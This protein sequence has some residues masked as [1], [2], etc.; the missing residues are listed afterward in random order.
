MKIRLFSTL[1]SFLA[2]TTASGFAQG[3][4][5]LNLP[6]GQSLLCNQLDHGSNTADILFP[7]PSG[8]RD[9]DQLRYEYNC[10][11][12]SFTIVTFDSAQ[13]TGFGDA[14]DINPVPAPVL[15]PGTG[16]FYA[17]NSVSN[18]ITFTGTPHVPVLPIRGLLTCGDGTYYVL[19]RQTNDIGTYE[20]ITGFSPQEGS[21]VQTWNGFGFVTNR[22]SSG[23]WTLGAPSLGVGQA[24]KFFIPSGATSLTAR[25]HINNHTMLEAMANGYYQIQQE[26]G[27]D[28]AS[29]INWT[30]T[31]N[32]TGWTG[33][34]IGTLYNKSLTINYSGVTAYGA[35]QNATN[36]F[37]ASG[38]NGTNAIT[39][40]GAAVWVYN[41]VTGGYT[42]M[43][44]ED[45]GDV[46]TPRLKW[47]VVAVEVVGGGAVGALFDDGAGAL[48]GAALG[49]SISAAGAKNSINGPDPTNPGTPTRPS[50][51]ATVDEG[52]SFVPAT[53]QL[54]TRVF[55]TGTENANVRN[56]VFLSGNWASGHASGFGYVGSSTMVQFAGLTHTAL[57]N[58]GLDLQPNR[59]TVAN[60]GT[61][62]QDGVEI[63]LPSVEAWEGHWQALDP[64]NG[65]P[66]GAYL[67]SQ[68]FG[69][70][71]SVSNGLLGSWQLTKAGTSNYVVTADFL[72]MGAT[73]VTLQV[74]DGTN[75]VATSS[76]QSGTLGTLNG[77]VDDDH[78]GNPVPPGPFGLPGPFGG[79]L[80]MFGPVS[81]TFQGGGGTVQGDRLVILP[82]GASPV[83]SLSRTRLLASGIPQIILTEEHVVTL[84]GFELM[85]V[86]TIL[87]SLTSG[88]TR[89]G[90]FLGASD[91][92]NTTW[93]GSYTVSNW[94]Y[95]VS[96]TCNG[97]SFSLDYVGT[98]SN[99]WGQDVVVSFT[100]TGVANTVTVLIQGQMLWKYDSTN[101]DYLGMDYS[102]LSKF[103][104]NTI[105]GWVVG[106]EVVVGVATGVAVGVGLGS[107][108][109]PAG[110][111]AGVK[112]GALATGL[113]VGISA[114][115]KDTLALRVGPPPEPPGPDAPSI[116]DTITVAPWLSTNIVTGINSLQSS[117][118]A[119]GF[120][121]SAVTGTYTT[122]HISGAIGPIT[123]GQY[124]GLTHTSLGKA[125]LSVNLNQLTINNLGTNGQDGV[126]I[127][128]N[129][130]ESFAAQW[131]DLDPTQTLAVGA[132]LQ[133]NAIGTGGSVSN[134]LLGSMRVTKT[135]TSNYIV[136]AN[137]PSSG[138][139]TFT[140]RVYNG[141]NLAASKG[142]LSGTLC[143]VPIWPFDIEPCPGPYNPY[144]PYDEIGGGPIMGLTWHRPGPWLIA[145]SGGPTVLGDAVTIVPDD[146]PSV[147]S[148][149]SVQLLASGISQII[150]TNEN[151]SVE[152]AGLRHTSLGDA[153]FTLLGS[154]PKLKIENLGSSG[155]DGVSIALHDVAQW[156]AA[157][158]PLEQNGTPLPE[159]AYLQMQLIGTGN[160]RTND[161]V[162]IVTTTMGTSSSVVS[163][164]FSMVGATNLTVQVYAGT[165]LVGQ[166]TGLPMGIIFRD[167]NDPLPF[168]HF[169][170]DC[171]ACSSYGC[172]TPDLTY[173]GTQTFIIGTGNEVFSGDRVLIIPQG[174]PFEGSISTVNLVASQIPAITFTNEV[175]S[176]LVL[177]VSSSSTKL[178]LKWFGTGQPQ[179]SSNLNTWTDVTN[180]VSPF[181]V[182]I[183]P[184]NQFYRIK[185]SM[186]HESF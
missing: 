68:I 35:N 49:L 134:G 73:T 11:N 5:T 162:G 33:S 182:P 145:V 186:G 93:S 30:A 66:V 53:N 149:S 63:A 37:S 112:A 76:G 28:P 146:L 154:R 140:V 104:T 183:G 119:Y 65:L 150:I 18:S 7:N 128:L 1:V 51:P 96:G 114:G 153:S 48:A 105:W 3:G 160:G 61:N 147:I 107:L 159:G 158:E 117:V 22:F 57:S 39:I 106:G 137:F 75:L 127:A 138:T 120:A 47:W 82:E 26:F 171:S 77:C 95:T 20:N 88:T 23:A 72:P 98:L 156:A 50:L 110:V 170:C 148:L 41:P 136:T 99:S 184:T 142:G 100:G 116:T 126:E 62:G 56:Q 25:E 79:G 125:M 32:A 44:F 109:P 167:P 152:Y 144:P 115:I 178:K 103:G 163:A 130:K 31:Y 80:T 166:V 179:Q 2:L 14:L 177:N 175:V 111:V 87:E 4:Y 34:V 58:A 70:A 181:V 17:N 54:V 133:M 132:Y 78:W 27:L 71:G 36:T 141:T 121:A 92:S 40:N 97:K 174:P 101:D 135:A 16:F 10:T 60:I 42:N 74:Y 15:A 89:V 9:G 29:T 90:E 165:T 122:G 38:V 94:T 21:E 64:T 6:V 172:N 67:E 108:L 8:Q 123:T 143:T 173:C 157:W 86:T 113:L 55:G 131:E 91:F 12:A 45:H 84:L 102:D 19:S 155:Q 176:P 52:V 24:A 43:D 169:P 85:N 124:A 118:F 129:G 69:T 164:D 168:P 180:A 161:I 46:E 151:V 59:L 83:S 185:Q 13:P 139:N 81:F